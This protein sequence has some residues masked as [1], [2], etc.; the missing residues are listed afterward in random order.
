MI[1]A[2]GTQ[3]DLRWPYFPVMR[4]D[5]EPP[6][7]SD[8][9]VASHEKSVV[10]ELFPVLQQAI[11]ELPEGRYVVWEVFVDE[12]HSRNV[13]VVVRS[14]DFAFFTCVLLIAQQ[15]ECHFRVMTQHYSATPHRETFCHLWSSCTH[16][17]TTLD[18][19]SCATRRSTNGCLKTT[20]LD[21]RTT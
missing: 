14:C 5:D 9:F 20:E 8:D 3:T 13:L 16:R 1:V 10:T 2:D 6:V 18:F 21:E 12:L 17:C 11:K 7:V 15:R 4:R 19:S